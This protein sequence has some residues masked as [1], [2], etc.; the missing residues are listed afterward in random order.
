M[1]RAMIGTVDAVIAVAEAEGIDADICRTEELMVATN[2]AQMERLRQDA[3][4]RAGWGVDEERF[5][6]LDQGEVLKAWLVL[7]AT[8]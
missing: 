5:R 8:S 2:A 3:A 1:I 6:L 4:E 7:M